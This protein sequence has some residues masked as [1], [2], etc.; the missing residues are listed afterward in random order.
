M[1]I[2]LS[3]IGLDLLIGRLVVREHEHRQAGAELQRAAQ[4][5][6]VGGD[7]AFHGRQRIGREEDHLALYAHT[8]RAEV[9][10]RHDVAQESDLD[11]AFVATP[12]TC[13]Q[14]MRLWDAFSRCVQQM[15]LA[16]EFSGWVYTMHS[17]LFLTGKGIYISNH[18]NASSPMAP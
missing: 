6:L 15:R 3:V 12:I 11:P 5:H 8:V 10:V 4:C 16:G 13:V 7:G 18:P 2:S 14:Q 17:C 9:A 1:V